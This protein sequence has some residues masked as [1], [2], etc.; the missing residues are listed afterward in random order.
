M[1]KFEE[2][3][4]NFMKEHNIFAEFFSFEESCHS[5][6]EAAQRINAEKNEI[7]KNI[8]FI[9]D[10]GEII[11]AIVRGNDGISSS[12]IMKLLSTNIRMMT[13][14]EIIEKTGYPCGG[15]P[16]FGFKALFLID[17]KVMEKDF[18][19]TSGGSENSLIKISTKQL[20][21]ANNGRIA[22]IR[23]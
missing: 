15:V 16:S 4:R 12:K 9:D 3:L 8:C 21:N 18:V 13:P 5:V 17:K 20:Q 11:V 7:I 22:D 10:K 2:K 23:K 19:Y 1:N 6:K 14:E